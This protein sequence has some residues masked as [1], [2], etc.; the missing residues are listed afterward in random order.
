[1][2]FMFSED[3]YSSNAHFLSVPTPSQSFDGAP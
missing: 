2:I 3:F 1:M